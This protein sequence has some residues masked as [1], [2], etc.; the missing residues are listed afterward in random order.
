MTTRALVFDIGNTRVKWGVYAEGALG[1]TGSMTHAALKEKGVETLTRR[2]PRR[3]DR[4]LAC[5]VAGP[6]IGRRLARAIGI[7]IGGDLGYVHSEARGY[8]IVNAYKRPRTLGV[9]R[10]VAMVAARDEFDGALL[11]VDLGT[12]VT[13][14]ALDADGWHLGG[15]IL[16]GLALMGDALQ[17]NTSDIGTTRPKPPRIDS[18]GDLF[19][20]TTSAAVACGT[21]GAVCGAIERAE[22]MMASLGHEPTLVLTGGDASRILGVLGGEPEHRPHLVLEGLGVIA[23]GGTGGA[24]DD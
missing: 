11:V 15:Q 2:L 21:L 4:A 13:I 16:P 14:D 10:W 1:R 3:V 5:N 7:H 9:D 23:C 18:P 6:D 17:T 22:V 24:D 20:T 8:G 19:A 12:A